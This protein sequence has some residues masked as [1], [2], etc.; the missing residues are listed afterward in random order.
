MATP[1]VDREQVYRPRHKSGCSHDQNHRSQLPGVHVYLG[2]SG[3]AG[4]LDR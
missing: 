3:D 4:A 1:E 2:F